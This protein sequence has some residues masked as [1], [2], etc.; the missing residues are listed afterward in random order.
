MSY[1]YG[2]CGQ[3]QHD[4]NNKKVMT[5]FHWIFVKEN[6]IKLPSLKR[7]INLWANLNTLL[8]NK[9]TTTDECLN[10]FIPECPLRFW[11]RGDGIKQ[12]Q[13]SGLSRAAATTTTEN[14]C[15]KQRF[16]FAFFSFLTKFNCFSF[17]KIEKKL[18]FFRTICRFE[19]QRVFVCERL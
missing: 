10:S 17:T 19:T 12:Q 6:K 3:Q 11:L 5:L 13:Q 18:R 15:L 9:T 16:F 8:K 1:F 7:V 14:C 4:H 2:H